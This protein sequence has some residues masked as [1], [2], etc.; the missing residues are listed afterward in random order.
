MIFS[1]SCTESQGNT[2]LRVS[3]INSPRTGEVSSLSGSQKP[4]STTKGE[5][6]KEGGK[7]GR[8]KKEGELPRRGMKRDALWEDGKNGC[9]CCACTDIDRAGHATGCLSGYSSG[10]SPRLETRLRIPDLCGG[11]R[12]NLPTDSNNL[13]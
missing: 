7:G 8:K 3:E 5:G 9:G 2:L 1:S 6:R 10:S 13:L 12:E 4:R 11:R